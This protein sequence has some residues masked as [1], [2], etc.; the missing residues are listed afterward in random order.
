MEAGKHVLRY[1]KGSAERGLLYRSVGLPTGTLELNGVV[2]Y[3]FCDHEDR[4]GFCDSNWGPQD[5]SHP[6]GEA[7]DTLNV[8][9]A[10]S[11]QGALIV[12]IGGCHRLER[13]A[14]EMR[15]RSHLRGRDQ[16]TR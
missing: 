10:R 7:N 12:Q 3:P 15:E 9:E 8:E 5:A 13:N 2:S 4:I 6:M 16:V 11:L 1:L 14:R